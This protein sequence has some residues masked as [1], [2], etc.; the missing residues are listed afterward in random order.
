MLLQFVTIS[1]QLGSHRW[2]LNPG[3]HHYLDV[4]DQLLH[5]GKNP[6]GTYFDEPGGA[7]DVLQY[8]R[9]AEVAPFHSLFD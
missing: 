9:V 6:T 2:K 1:N 8:L 7:P 5:T 3:K 4:A